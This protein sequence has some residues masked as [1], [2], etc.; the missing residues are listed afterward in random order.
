MNNV[1]AERGR[2]ARIAEF[3]AEERKQE[4]LEAKEAE[5]RR[6]NATQKH[7]DRVERRK[8]RQQVRRMKGKVMDKIRQQVEDAVSVHRSH[9]DQEDDAGW[10]EQERREMERRQRY[11]RERST[12]LGAML[13]DDDDHA[14]VAKDASE[15][16]SQDSVTQSKRQFR[17]TKMMLDVVLPSSARDHSSRQTSLSIEEQKE[18]QRRY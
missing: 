10:K 1:R 16:V 13:L 18:E 17:S 15:L 3:E 6:R 5:K 11:R 8:R 12:G 14:D 9:G 4:E 7:K 2:L